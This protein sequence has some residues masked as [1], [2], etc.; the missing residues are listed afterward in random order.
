MANINI[1]ST[2]LKNL[3]DMT[4][5]E[6]IPG[7]RAGTDRRL[8]REWDKLSATGAEEPENK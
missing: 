4:P 3:L 8:A 2:E 1:N 7:A 6:E 5:A